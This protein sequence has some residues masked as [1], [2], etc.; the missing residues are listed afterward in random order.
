MREDPWEPPLLLVMLL[1]CVSHNLHK[2]RENVVLH[3][4][5]R[6]K[7]EQSSLFSVTFFFSSNRSQLRRLC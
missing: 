3:S 7:G 1:V 4:K 5:N 6:K 2:H